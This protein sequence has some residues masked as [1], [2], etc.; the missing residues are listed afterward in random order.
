MAA[1]D[2]SREALLLLI[3]RMEHEHGQTVI[4]NFALDEQ[5]NRA[6]Q[7]IINLHAQIQTAVNEAQAVR[8]NLNQANADNEELRCQ[9]DP[10]RGDRYKRKKKVTNGADANQSG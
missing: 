5:L 1:I 2:T 4:A 10:N 8:A 6:E 9:L 3:S 7:T